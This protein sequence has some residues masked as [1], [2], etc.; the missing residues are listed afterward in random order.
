MS[1]KRRCKHINENDIVKIMCLHNKGLDAQ[2]I[3]DIIDSSKTT[4]R[5]V[6]DGTHH[7]L[8]EKKSE[9]EAQPIVEETQA[10]IEET[11]SENEN[12][13]IKL[14]YNSDVSKPSITQ[15]L[16]EQVDEIVSLLKE[17]LNFCK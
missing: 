10:V 3:A 13:T 2:E 1:E 7:L 5:R 15:K 12:P 17:I 11:Q 14:T 9:E 4:V 8:I 6:L 16:E